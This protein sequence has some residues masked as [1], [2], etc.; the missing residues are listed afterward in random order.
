MNSQL[1]TKIKIFSQLYVGLKDQGVGQPK[2]GFATPFEKGSAFEKRKSTV[3]N[4]A[5]TRVYK[6]D[7]Q[8]YEYSAPEVTTVE[9]ELRSGFKITDDVRRIYWGGGNVVWRVYDPLGF[10]LEITSGNLMAIIQVCGIDPGGNIRGKCCWGRDG[11]VNV[12]LHEDS[13]VYQNAFKK[14]EDL[15]KM[16]ALSA[17]TK[18]VGAKYILQDGQEVIYLGKFHTYAVQTV[19]FDKSRPYETRTVKISGGNRF[20]Q[21]Q[22]KQIVDEGI[23][24]AVAVADGKIALYKKAPLISATSDKT[25]WP[26]SEIEKMVETASVK[27]APNSR[28][29]S[30]SILI[31]RTPKS[32]LRFAFKPMS[33]LTYETVRDKLIKLKNINFLFYDSQFKLPVGVVVDGKEGM[34]W[35]RTET[36]GGYNNCNSRDAVFTPSYIDGNRLCDVHSIDRTSGSN[37][38]TETDQVFELLEVPKFDEIFAWLQD[39]YE[40][41]LLKETVMVGEPA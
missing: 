26:E 7:T 12:L 23:Y 10:E 2:L 14:A 30:T 1:N 13:D 36:P 38:L 39:K 9:N 29:Y 4:W 20:A 33:L 22:T 16:K 5:T 11:A 17:K 40:N 34:L 27:F 8:K 37:R 25:I 32:S 24:E 6:P 19:V 18:A 21:S 31:S 15:N 35:G 3:D 41:G 28:K